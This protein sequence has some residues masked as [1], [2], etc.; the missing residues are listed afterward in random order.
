[1]SV[2]ER[3]RHLKQALVPRGTATERAAKSGVWVVASNVLDRG[4]QMAMVVVLARLLSPRA[5]GLLG[6]GLVALEALRR[7]S[8]LGIQSA[9]VQKAD[10]DVDQYLNTAWCLRVVR[11]AALAVALFVV[12]PHVAAFFDEPRATDVVRVIAVSPVLLGLRNPSTVYFQKHLEHHKQFAYRLSGSVAQFI[13]AVGLSLVFRSVW[14]LVIG[15]V[16]ADA[17]RLVASYLLDDY[18]PWPAFAGTAAAELLGYGKW[19]TSAELL[20]FLIAQLDDAIVGWVLGMSS[21]GIYQLAY[22]FAKA[23]ATEITQVVSSVTFPMYSA[24]QDDADALREA[25]FTTVRLTTVVSFPT[26]VGIAAVAPTFVRAFFGAEWQPMVPVLQLVAAYGL[27]VSLVSTFSPIW[28]T[29]GRPDYLSKIALVR[30]V[31]IALFIYP[32]TVRFGIAGTAAVVA[33]AYVV[34]ALPIEFYLVIDVVGTS[35][36]RFFRELS[37][38]VVASAGMGVVVRWVRESTALDSSVAGFFLLVGVGVVAYLVSAV[39]VDR[40]TRWDLKRDCRA[41]RGAVLD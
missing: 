35:Y 34:P 33:G 8:N 31:T 6:V 21:L 12:A 36:R 1:M 17:V 26:A 9:L 10:D 25:F 19:L 2:Q 4:L 3:L 37:Y 16:T 22:R 20:W 39:A 41:V 38:P 13:V 27:L 18:R 14:P 23:P 5:F 7:A 32:A 29:L 24:L 11:G 30:V 28:K 40:W 15:F